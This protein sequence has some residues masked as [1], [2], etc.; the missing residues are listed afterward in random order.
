MTT[1]G[2]MAGR[3]AGVTGAGRGI[4]AATALLLAQHG[5]RVVLAARSVGELEATATAITEAGGEA[6]AVPCDV[7]VDD[8]AQE[9][10]LAIGPGR[11]T[12]LTLEDL[13]W[14]RPPD[15]ELAVNPVKT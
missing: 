9:V 7:S 11:E 10:R 1:N 4:G 3:V 13:N 8:E 2:P 6:L 15:P 14:A 12:V 5:A